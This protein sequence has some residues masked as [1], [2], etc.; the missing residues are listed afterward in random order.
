MGK[1]KFYIYR[2]DMAKINPHLLYTPKGKP[3][4]EDKEDTKEAKNKIEDLRE[5]LRW[6]KNKP[7]KLTL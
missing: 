6:K 2:P 5:E 3:Y 1:I 4:F 7:F